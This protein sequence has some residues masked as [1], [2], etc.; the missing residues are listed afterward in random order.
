M[1]CFSRADPLGG[2]RKAGRGW[3]KSPDPTPLTIMKCEICGTVHEKYQAH[4]F[5]SNTASN[6]N[7]SN[8]LGEGPRPNEG[9]GVNGIGQAVADLVPGQVGDGGLKRCGGETKQRWSRESYNAYQREY[10]RTYRLGKKNS[11]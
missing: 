2:E 8:R 1:D 11:T 5:A 6:V 10:M 3:N 4:K 9:V 7:A